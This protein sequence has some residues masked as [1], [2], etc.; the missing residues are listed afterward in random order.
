MSEELKA[1]P[2]CGGEAI[3]D[4]HEGSY[5]FNAW[6]D[7]NCL[8]CEAQIGLVAESDSGESL[9][10]HAVKKWNTRQPNV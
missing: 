1:C 9:R 5:E 6:A 10:E 2:F 4:Y 3:I 7:I 8:G